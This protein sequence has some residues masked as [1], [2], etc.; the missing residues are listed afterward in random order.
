MESFKTVRTPKC[1]LYLGAPLLDYFHSGD[2][3]NRKANW[4]KIQAQ[5]VR[6]AI[7]IYDSLPNLTFSLWSLSNPVTRRVRRREIMFL[8][9][10]I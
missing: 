6:A 7:R 5:S 4:D 2:I 8:A 9:V 3:I 10:K 1:L